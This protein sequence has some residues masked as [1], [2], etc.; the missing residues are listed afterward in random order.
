MQRKSEKLVFSQGYLVRKN[1]S[2]KTLYRI[3][4]G[5]ELKIK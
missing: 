4:K 2:L 3:Y 5:I 1:K